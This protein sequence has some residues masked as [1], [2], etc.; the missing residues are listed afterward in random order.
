MLDR[1]DSNKV[2]FHCKWKIDIAL[3][4]NNLSP[5]KFM[6]YASIAALLI[7]NCAC[8]AGDGYEK[9]FEHFY[10]HS[11]NNKDL[12]STRD[13]FGDSWDY[14]CITYSGRAPGRTIKIYLPNFHSNWLNDDDIVD[15]DF[16]D[17]FNKITL[18]NDSKYKIYILLKTRLDITEEG[19]FD[20]KRSSIRR[21][22]DDRRNPSEL[23]SIEQDSK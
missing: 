4:K 20:F 15:F 2:Q 1:L 22:I 10:L 11:L 8:D 3:F 14:I 12:S 5:I 21:I 23:L 16:P 9:R 7:S 17:G 18:I 13:V 19:C 6:Y